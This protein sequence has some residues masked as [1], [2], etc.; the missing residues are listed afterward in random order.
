MEAAI[1]ITLTALALGLGY[2][3]TRA[4]T[5]HLG[6]P[7]GGGEGDEWEEGSGHAAGHWVRRD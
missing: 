1:T 5:R 3:I 7:D 2:L 6:E 4:M